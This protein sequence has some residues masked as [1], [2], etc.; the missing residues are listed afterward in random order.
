MDGARGQWCLA[1]DGV[2]K[3]FGG[4]RAVDGVSLQIRAGERRAIIGPN[5]AGKTTLFNLIS[6]EL[7]VT[8]GR[9]ALFGQDITALPS[10]RR[11]ALGMGRTYQI[12]NLF[13][14]LTVRENVVLA[15]LGTQSR[16]FVMH[17]PVHGDRDLT[18]Q[19]HHLLHGVGLKDKADVML[20]RLSYGEQRQVELLLALA[21]K[22]AMLLLDEPTAGLS[23]GERPA[24]A[25]TI[26]GLDPSI[27]VLLI[28]HDMDV[29]FEV[30]ERVSVLHLG[31]VLAEGT[32]DE[33][34]AD[35]Q[36]R[37]IYLGTEH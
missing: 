37:Q 21:S 29:A 24:L 6:G 7:P 22:P 13:P 32:P 14:Q 18:D 31:R 19:A 25:Q 35:P 12:T 1:L 26:R 2:A 28:E 15:L 30:A 5:G 33:I 3:T 9:V 8:S 17:R 34:R 20:T 36:V 10:F 4:L 27:T 11:T 16:K 23:P